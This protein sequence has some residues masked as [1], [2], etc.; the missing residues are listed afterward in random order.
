MW[1]E[2]AYGYGGVQLRTLL[3]KPKFQ[4]Y[5]YL[6]FEYVLLNRNLSQLQ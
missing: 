3:Y 5:H 6:E 1:A 2:M 4:P